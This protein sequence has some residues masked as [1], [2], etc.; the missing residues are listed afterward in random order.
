[1]QKGFA[2]TLLLLIVLLSL[3]GFA[4]YWFFLR[5]STPPVIP[6]KTAFP[7]PDSENLPQNTIFKN[8]EIGLEISLPPGFSIKQETEKDYFKRANGDTRKN[9]TYYVQYP[10]PEFVNSFYVME[11]G[12]NNPDKAKLSILVFKNPENMEPQKFY[13]EYWYYPFIWGE[14]SLSEKNKFAPQAIE[15][16]DGRESGTA[17]ADFRETKPKFIYLPYKQK[18]LMLQIQMPT[19]N[20][21]TGNQILKS[22]KLSNPS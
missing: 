9:F 19:E 12:E 2:Q 5:S 3:G 7:L 1:M 6:E 10:P 21:Q 20:N 15:L 4:L 22:L 18:N 13:Q 17:V 14:F 8:D 16:I 11:A